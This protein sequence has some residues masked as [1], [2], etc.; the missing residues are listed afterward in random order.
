MEDF[1]LATDKGYIISRELACYT[2]N[3]VSDYTKDDANLD[4]FVTIL[5]EIIRRLQLTIKESR[6]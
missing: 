1:N 2:I 6:V 4:T 3:K 5:E